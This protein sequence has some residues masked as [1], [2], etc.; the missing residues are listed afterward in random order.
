MLEALLRATPS[1]EPGP[2][3]LRELCQDIIFGYDGRSR[4]FHAIAL[5]SHLARGRNLLG[6]ERISIC[7]KCNGNLIG[8]SSLE[9]RGRAIPITSPLLMAEILTLFPAFQA[10]FMGRGSIADPTYLVEDNERPDQ[11]VGIKTFSANVKYT[12]PAWQAFEA[13]VQVVGPVAT[14]ETE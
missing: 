13:A 9:G 2:L 7:L 12:T 14:V 1:A 11:M 8:D 5:P 4:N 10:Q 3:E 6:D